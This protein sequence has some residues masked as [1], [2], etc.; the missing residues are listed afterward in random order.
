MK[1]IDNSVMSTIFP[2][3]YCLRAGGTA[4]GAK[5]ASLKFFS[6]SSKFIVVAADNVITLPFR[7]G[8]ETTS[9]VHDGKPKAPTLRGTALN[10]SVVGEKQPGGVTSKMGR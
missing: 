10:N 9:V 7:G 5:K 4:A 2:V 1:R 6:S 8:D 3:S